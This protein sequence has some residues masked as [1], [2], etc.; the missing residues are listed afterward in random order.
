MKKVLITIIDSTQDN[1][2]NCALLSLLA[3]ADAGPKMSLTAKDLRTHN[4]LWSTLTSKLVSYITASELQDFC[5]HLPAFKTWTRL[6]AGGKDSLNMHSTSAHWKAI[7]S[8]LHARRL[9][10]ID[11][12]AMEL[13]NSIIA[14]ITD[15]VPDTDSLRFQYIPNIQYDPEL[16]TPKQKQILQLAINSLYD[17]PDNANNHSQDLEAFK[18]TFSQTSLSTSQQV[19]KT[20]WR[21]F[22][23][24]FQ[25]RVKNHLTDFYTQKK[26]PVKT[27]APLYNALINAH[28]WPL[29]CM[30]HGIEDTLK[31]LIHTHISMNDGLAAKALEQEIHYFSAAHSLAYQQAHKHLPQTPPPPQATFTKTKNS[32]LRADRRDACTFHYSLLLFSDEPTRNTPQTILSTSSTS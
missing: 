15:L 5:T 3:I 2:H 27:L 11:P 25:T 8:T 26:S 19:C 28:I 1:T 20:A 14:C 17:T 12:T 24:H 7:S 21:T 13:W 22:Y 9:Q 4:A 16:Y 18:K 30:K 6:L 23:E 32:P 10:P 29:K 31:D